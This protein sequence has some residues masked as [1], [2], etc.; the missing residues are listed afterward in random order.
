VVREET[1]TSAADRLLW[2][3]STKS[4]RNPVAPLKR[5]SLWRRSFAFD[6]IWLPADFDV[7]LRLVLE[8]SQ[9]RSNDHGD[10]SSPRGLRLCDYTPCGPDRRTPW[11]PRCG[12]TACRRGRSST[13]RSTIPLPRLRRTGARADA[14][15]RRHCGARQPRRP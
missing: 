1:F 3:R 8:R 10:G 11:S 7:S 5:S 2:G 13:A 14:A 6:D 12:G 15:T 9:R 4:G